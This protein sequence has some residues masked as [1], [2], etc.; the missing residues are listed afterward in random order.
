MRILVV[1]L[2]LAGCTQ[3]PEST[4][5]PTRE[6]DAAPAQRLVGRQ[7]SEATVREAQRLSH[8]NA[9]RV[10]RPGQIITMEYRADRVNIRI[11]TQEKILAITCG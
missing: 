5:P 1:A 7:R 11:D 9:V 2:A 6:C 3:P 8:A 10:L 4:P